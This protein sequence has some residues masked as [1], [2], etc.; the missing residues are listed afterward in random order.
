VIIRCILARIEVY[1]WMF[2]AP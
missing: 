2:W 1:G